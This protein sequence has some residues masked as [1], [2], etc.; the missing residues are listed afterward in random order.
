MNQYNAYFEMCALVFLAVVAFH[1]FTKPRYPT[2]QNRFFAAFVVVGMVDLMADLL[3]AYCIEHFEIVPLSLNLALN[4]VYYLCQ[5]TLAPM[6]L[7]YTLCLSDALNRKNA[8]RICLSLVPAAVAA[9]MVLP[10][11]FFGY[12]FYFDADM[13]YHRGALYPVLFAETVGYLLFVFGYVLVKRKRLR[14]IVFFT[15]L[16][17]IAIVVV[18]SVLQ[19]FFPAYLITGAA[20]SL[21]ILMM[22]LTLQNPDDVLDPLTGALSRSSFLLHTGT[23]LQRKKPF[24]VVMFEIDGMSALNSL[25]GLSIGDDIISG[26][27]AFLRRVKGAGRFF[28]VIGDSFAIV[29]EDE[30]LCRRVVSDTVERFR[31]NWQMQNVTIQLSISI[32][33]TLN[34]ER[35]LDIDEL[36]TLLEHGQTD[37]RKQ[38]RGGVLQ[39]DDAM[40]ERLRRQ[41]VIESILRDSLDRH[42]LEMHLQPII[43]L[44]SGRITGAEALVR[45]RDPSGRLVLPDE[46]IP[47]AERNGL[48]GRIG[49]E[50]IAS[51][52]AF[53]RDNDLVAD[54]RFEGV[55]VNLSVVECLDD[56]LEAR[57]LDISRQYG[58]TPDKLCFEIT[59]TT[60]SM[61]DDLPRKMT[62]LCQAGF[63]F[64]L[65]DFGTG[66]ANYDSIMRLPFY[67]VKMDKTM[68]VYKGLSEK[69][70]ALFT[71]TVDMVRALGLSVI[72]EGVETARQADSLKQTGVV[73][74][75]GYHFAR[76]M[77]SDDFVALYRAQGGAGGRAAS[78]A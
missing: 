52:C 56:A 38:G 53:M 10:N 9:L 47:I 3:S 71:R 61:S 67:C 1:F 60:A 18:A 31:S 55:C 59:E 14:A 42:A 73:Y 35:C 63:K 45:L 30:A 25:F 22:Y 41:S 11:V 8:R 13:V 7:L 40:L 26:I 49:T 32:C 77:P 39:I 69:S 75:Q 19:A 46:F 28:R 76:P 68:L 50:V 74:A 48:I 54:P 64:A 4:S 37:M 6:L 29:T 58:I 44:S 66:Y 17:F 15:M 33:Y 72:A 16:A 20:L 43:A 12:Y 24:Q 21:A 34:A 27:G 23:L 65:D 70:E 2:R 51:A 78:Q 57:I 62:A 36:T 5:I